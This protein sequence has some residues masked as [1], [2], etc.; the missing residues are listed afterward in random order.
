MRLFAELFTRLDET[1]K[2]SAKH[3]ALVDYFRKAE[4][5][6]A[7]WAVHVL[8][9]RKLKR[10]IKSGDLRAAAIGAAG[11][12]EW[13]F[14][15]SYEVV[16]DLA[17]T[18]ALLLPEATVSSAEPLHAVIEDTLLPLK[19]LSP[20]E[21]GEIL[22]SKWSGLNRAE[23]FV[24]N[25]LLTGSFRVGVQQ[26]SVTKA[27][28]EV[29]EI[30][31][32]LVAHRLMGQWEPTPEFF[33]SLIST[34]DDG[35]LEASR[36]YPFFLAHPLEAEPSSLGEVTQWQVEWKWDGIRA[37]MIRRSGQ[38]FLWSRGEELLTERFPDLQP[39]IEA[40]PDGTALDGEL[41]AMKE[42]NVLPFGELQ[43]RIGRKTL[44]KKILSDVPAHF[45]AFDLLEWD[46]A[47]VRTWPMAKRR[48]RLASLVESLEIRGEGV[49][50]T[51]PLEGA[52]DRERL[53]I[54]LSEVVQSPS[55]EDL[56]K[57]RETSR[58][59]RAEGLMLKRNDSEYGVGRVRGPWW[60][61]KIEPFTVDAVMIYAQR[62][63][64]RR[65]SLY[66]DYTF[67]AWN[68]GELVPFAKAYSGL[69]DEEIGKVDRWIRRNTIER[70]GP[71]R[72]VKPEQVFELA[73]EDI[74]LS[75]R[76]KSGIAVRFPRITK[77]RTD[78]KADEAD[79]LDAIKKLLPD[80]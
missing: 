7:A 10:V 57:L 32:A 16:G 31:V 70:F 43:R 66:S 51:L 54:S 13:L 44:G 17:E 77:W 53:A 56:A 15:E 26:R 72:S 68:E 1:N 35:E 64:G 39:V 19:K 22:W 60:K 61:W 20:E 3:A 42:G 27:L 37:Q 18:I 45:I 14:E 55:W 74:R 73:F 8:T 58:E 36:P 6:D 40:L 80:I 59:R 28:A 34:E 41:V 29:A 79:A 52:A 9:G 47:D 4:P 2:T 38:S 67:A 30:D 76:H 69:T 33:R 78:K 49:E 63:H 75:S 12:S 48:A 46:G 23:R 21:Q 25:K 11:V 5:E 50:S 24:F 65:A 71:V 62:G